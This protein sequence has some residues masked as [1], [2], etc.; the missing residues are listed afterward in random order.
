MTISLVRIL[1]GN[2]FTLAEHLMFLFVCL[3]CNGAQKC[4][5]IDPFSNLNTPGDYFGYRFYIE[6]LNIQNCDLGPRNTRK[7]YKVIGNH[8]VDVFQKVAF[9]TK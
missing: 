9:L 1:S 8:C 2:I 5:K 4:C 6:Y 3:F 7:I